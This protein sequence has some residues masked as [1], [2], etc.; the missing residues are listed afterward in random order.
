MTKWCDRIGT[1]FR[2]N[3]SDDFRQEFGNFNANLEQ[4]YCVVGAAKM[5]QES[6]N[7]R[8]ILEQFLSK[9]RPR[10]EGLRYQNRGDYHH[11]DDCSTNVHQW[12]YTSRRRR[13]CRSLNCGRRAR[14]AA[15]DRIIGS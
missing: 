8:A 12:G 5:G 4:G 10:L 1:N 3:L 13:R 6:C 11:N 7:F 15:F 2:S 9:K 14:G